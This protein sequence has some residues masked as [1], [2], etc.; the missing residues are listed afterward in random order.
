MIESARPDLGALRLSKDRFVG[1]LKDAVR[2]ATNDY[3]QIN[4]PPHKIRA[5]VNQLGHLTYRPVLS[6]IVLI[7]L[8]RVVSDVKISLSHGL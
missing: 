2:G 8:R 6:F 7:V 1:T 4:Y 5:N 3:Q